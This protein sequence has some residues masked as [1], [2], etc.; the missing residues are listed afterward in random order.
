[1]TN[2]LAMTS[3][4]V[5]LPSDARMP[6]GMAWTVCYMITVLLMQPY[7][8]KVRLGVGWGEG[9][10]VPEWFDFCRARRVSGQ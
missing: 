4:I 8:R 1:M 6:V 2:K 3:I 9:G 10:S 5:F 7:L